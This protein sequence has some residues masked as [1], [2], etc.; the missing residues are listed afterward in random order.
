MG[1]QLDWQIETE[2][3]AA[4]AGEDPD[5]RR[6]RR[7]Q[8]A[9]ILVLTLAIIGAVLG[10]GALIFWRVTSVDNALK[11]GLTN[12]ARAEI[13]ALRISDL[14]GFLSIMR[15]GNADWV[16]SQSARFNRYQ[17]LKQ[18]GA[19]QFTE[20]F[21][22]VAIDGQRGRVLVEE[23]I[24]GQK[25]YALWYYWR[26]QD[27]WRHVPSDFTF[28]GEPQVIERK[29][30]TVRYKT[31]DGEFATQIA[32]KAERWWSE[33]CTY[34]GCATPP[35]LTIEISPE[36]TGA[37]RWSE[38]ASTQVLLIGSPLIGG[39][40][41]PAD[42]LLSSQ[43]E[44][45]IAGR[46]A[47][48]LFDLTTIQLQVN[49]NSD[50]AWVRQSVIEWLTAVMVGR[51]DL[52]Q[53]AFIQSLKEKYGAEGLTAV[54]KALSTD[55]DIGVVARALQRPLNTLDLDWRTFFQWRLSL[56]KDYIKVNNQREL[57]AL[58]DTTPEAQA[59]LRTR[60]AQPNAPLPQVQTVSVQ[61]ETATVNAQLNGQTVQV[62]FRIVNGAWRRFA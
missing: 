19:I 41:T 57:L 8:Q 2:R 35:P 36:L 49:P 60:A 38:D 25:H 20:N 24:N 54:I 58:W 45:A 27:G 40:R 10:F 7:Q 17:Q 44:D 37:P 51:G 42:L 3:E 18:T 12:A 6:Q 5:R 59:N 15:G 21:A 53:I 28:W 32:E 48:R 29:S 14:P 61:A 47:T 39:D 11:Q 22:D 56:E 46:L 31:L 23:Q 43:I 62:R 30:V 4:R 34:L 1:I 26:Y 16:P 52:T 55:S 9:A 50:A 33:S 13:A